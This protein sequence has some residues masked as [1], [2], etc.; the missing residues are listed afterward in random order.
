MPL[1]AKGKKIM[2]SMRET[3]PTEEKAKEVFY[4]S[5]NK[6][7]ISGVHRKGPKTLRDHKKMMKG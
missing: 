4:A 6:G 5:E 1:T 2:A 7:T 3:Y